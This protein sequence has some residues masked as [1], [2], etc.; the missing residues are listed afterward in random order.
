MRQPKEYDTITIKLDKR[1]SDKLTE[2]CSRSRMTK[3]ATIE[4]AL[5]NYISETDY[6]SQ[7][8]KIGK[9]N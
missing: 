2:Y 7:L 8:N 3:T 9:T 6:K 1:I 4:L 5:D